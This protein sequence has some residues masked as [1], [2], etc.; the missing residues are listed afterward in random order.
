MFKAGNLDQSRDFMIM[1]HTDPFQRARQEADQYV[2]THSNKLRAQKVDVRG[3]AIE[4]TS[5]A[6]L[7]GYLKAQNIDLVIMN[8]PAHTWIGGWFLGDR[9]AAIRRR[10]GI[11]V[12]NV[13]Q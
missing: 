12:L 4:G 9:A 6:T 8:R 13:N 5:L 1:A 3:H 2:R 7:C 10:T 11:T